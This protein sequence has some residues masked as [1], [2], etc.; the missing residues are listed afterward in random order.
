MTMLQEP[1]PD[2]E[3]L[4]ALAGGDPDARAD[5]TLAAHTAACERCTGIL[6]ELRS[7]TVA[8]AT[9]PDLAPPRPLRLLPPA[10]APQ[11]PS[12][13]LG[14]MRRLTA[15]AMA[16]AVVLIV[17]GAVGSGSALFRSAG[18]GVSDTARMAGGQPEMAAA[19]AAASVSGVSRDSVSQPTPTV[20]P[21]KAPVSV[22][23]TDNAY[24][25]QGVPAHDTGPLFEW[26]LGLGV[27]LLAAALL[28]R[29][30]FARGDR[31]D[32]AP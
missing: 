9:L 31:R 11:Q 18:A 17:V 20:A 1:H 30:V 3:R 12:A 23:T 21:P 26:F 24:G 6:A 29:A 4:A 22:G 32:R 27:V 2:D 25:G 19:S 8:L 16:L 7:V 15:P 13:W 14:I 5:A 28:A 10:D